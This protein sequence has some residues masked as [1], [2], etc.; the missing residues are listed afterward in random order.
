MKNSKAIKNATICAA[1]IALCYV[2]PIAFHSVGLGSVLSPLHLPV[3]LC[4]IVCGGWYGLF[5][6]IAGPLLSSVLSG[7][8]GP[9]MLITM[10]PE[11]MAYGLVTGIAMKY[12]RTGRTIADLYIA[13]IIAMIAGRIIGGLAQ[14]ASIQLIGIEKAFGIFIWINS[15]FIGTMPGILC[16]LAVIPVLVLTL[17]KAKVIPNRY[18]KVDVIYG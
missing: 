12:I 11:L 1:C 17:M 18:Q 14:I 4:G 15:Y 5:C 8:P 9:M 10:V 7:M 13:L 6:G 3:L 2:L 16:Q